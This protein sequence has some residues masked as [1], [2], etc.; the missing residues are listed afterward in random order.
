MKPNTIS[1]DIAQKLF[2][3][4]TKRFGNSMFA[5]VTTDKESQ[6]IFFRYFAE[7]ITSGALDHTRRAA[8][9]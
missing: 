3:R 8:N 6:R 2:A 5:C 7:A 9:Y 1:A 4:L